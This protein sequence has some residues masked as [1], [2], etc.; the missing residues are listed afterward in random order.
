M[1][2]ASNIDLDA[3]A[4][5]VGLDPSELRMDGEALLSRLALG[6]H[7]ADSAVTAAADGRA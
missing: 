1:G 6:E 2:N 7:D 3:L 5:R 4:A